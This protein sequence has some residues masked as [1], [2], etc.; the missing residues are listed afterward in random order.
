MQ[1]FS[2]NSQVTF[3]HAKGY[4]SHNIIV[5]IISYKGCNVFDIGWC[6]VW[7]DKYIR[8]LLHPDLLQ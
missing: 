5:W 4:L 6:M 8:E 7:A 3:M 1:L 2:F